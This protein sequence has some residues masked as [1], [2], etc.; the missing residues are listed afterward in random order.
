MVVAAGPNEYLCSK[1]H[2]YSLAAVKGA[3]YAHDV[4]TVAPQ[5][6]LAATFFHGRPPNYHGRPP[7][8][9]HKYSLFA[10]A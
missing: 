7:C 1:A 5:Q 4:K 6:N 8:N 2:K 9:L 3:N 10:I